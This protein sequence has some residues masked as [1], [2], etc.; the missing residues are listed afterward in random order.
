MGT[1]Q[2]P[3]IVKL[4]SSLS[5]PAFAVPILQGDFF[6]EKLTVVIIIG[7]GDGPYPMSW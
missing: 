6:N 1:I 3:K 2:H 5:S 4:L 7:L